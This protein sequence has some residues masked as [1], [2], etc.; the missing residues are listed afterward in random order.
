M[1]IA[2]IGGRG[3]L[4]AALSGVLQGDLLSLGSDAFDIAV[5]DQVRA[6]LDV[7]KPQ[8]VVNAAAYN[9]VDKAEDEPE[10]AYAVNALGPRNLATWCGQND[11]PIVHVSTDYIFG[12][13][14][15]RLAPYVENDLP[16]PLGAYAVSKLA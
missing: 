3:Q 8:L 10:R 6:R 16:G 1:R 4:G 11:V 13:D 2:L 5:L 14:T 7:E 15:T 12:L 9:F